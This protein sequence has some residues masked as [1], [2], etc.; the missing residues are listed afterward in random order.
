MEI[1]IEHVGGRKYLLSVRNASGRLRYY[2]GK[3]TL[4]SRK[5]AIENSISLFSSKKAAEWVGVRA[6]GKNKLRIS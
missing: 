6:H 2:N 5:S 4:G 1:N 3:A